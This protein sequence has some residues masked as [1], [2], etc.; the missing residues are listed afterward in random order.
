[1]IF[2]NPTYFLALL[3]LAVPL[4][5][6]LW[7][8]KEGRTIKIGS[9]QLLKQSDPKKSSSIKLN[10]LW[11]LL[12]R[13][14]VILI[15]VLILT[16]PQLKIKGENI[17]V[18]YLIEPSLLTYKNVKSLIDTLD[19]NAEKRLLQPGFPEYQK[20]RFEETAFSIPN[21]WQLTREMEGLRTDS[22]VVFTKAFSSGFRGKRP[23]ISKNITWIVL[24]SGGPKMGVLEAVQKGDLLELIS[25]KSDHQR[26]R[27]EKELLPLNSD[28]VVINANR[29]SVMISSSEDNKWLLLKKA[30]SLNVLVNYDEARFAEMKYISASFTAISKYLNRKIGVKTIKNLDTPKIE[31]Y[32][33]IVWLNEAP[34][35]QTEVPLLVFKPDSLANSIVVH[36]ASANIFHLTGSLNAENST[37]QHLPEHL[38][39]LLGI[40]GDLGEKVIEYDRR[41]MD[42]KELLPVSGGIVKSRNFSETLDLSKYLWI[43]LGLLIISERGLSAYRKQ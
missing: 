26:L 23:E 19:T 34:V 15:L 36:G 33:L 24:D 17:P 29:D 3:G 20:E 25:V 16:A 2:L 5:I 41:V 37:Q 27:F 32:N 28:G 11:L 40:H 6:H 39:S 9:I 42:S 14:L 21:Y 10:E 12:L 22:I 38:L 30:D 43:L 8:K 13:L 35:P 18:T 31:K 4:A 1:M 7:S